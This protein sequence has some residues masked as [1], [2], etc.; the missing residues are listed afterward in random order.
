MTAYQFV[1]VVTHYFNRIG[2]AVIQ[3]AEA[4]EV[5]DWILIEGPITQLEQRVHSMQIDYEALDIANPGEEIALKVEDR[6]RIN[7]EVFLV[8]EDAA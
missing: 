3:L 7:D 8:I 1:G 6:V 5:G 4:L 2:V